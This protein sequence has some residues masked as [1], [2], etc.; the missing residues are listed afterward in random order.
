MT[1]IKKLIQSSKNTLCGDAKSQTRVKALNTLLNG[2]HDLRKLDDKDLTEIWECIFYALWYAEMGRGCEEMIAAVERACTNNHKLS[3]AGFMIIAQKWYG[4]DQHRIDKVSHLARHLLG[5]IVQ[6]QIHR[7]FK[8]YQKRKKFASN[9]VFC[10][11]IIRRTLE[12][13]VKAEGLSYF[14]LENLSQVI[15]SS[16]ATTYERYNIT[17]GKFEL[18]A[19]LLVFIYKQVFVFASKLDFDSRLA[20]TF[21][22]FLIKRLLKDVLPNEAQLTQ[23]LVSL[24]LYQALEKISK[25][26]TLKTKPTL[27]RWFVTLQ[28]SHDNCI[29]GK[30]FTESRVPIKLSDR[31]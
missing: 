21:E 19:N 2:G 11:Q 20:S 22:Q 8:S 18:K 6:Q 31:V 30:E 27:H 16:L 3:R 5:T 26:S 4:L 9:D 13:V 14:I 17:V 25:K 23:I 1:T 29:N 15:T 10:K 24:R 28:N 12:D 7:W